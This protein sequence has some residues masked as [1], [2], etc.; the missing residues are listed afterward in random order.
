MQKEDDLNFSWSNRVNYDLGEKITNGIDILMETFLNI[1]A[2]DEKEYNL[3]MEGFGR[4][5]TSKF[6]DFRMKVI[7]YLLFLKRNDFLDKINKAK[8]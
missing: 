3:M 8:I 4:F 6:M 5:N 1:F 7:F 2:E